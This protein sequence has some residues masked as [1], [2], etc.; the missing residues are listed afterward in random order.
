VRNQDMKTAPV[1]VAKQNTEAADPAPTKEQDH[2]DS[3][4]NSTATEPPMGRVTAHEISHEAAEDMAVRLIMDGDPIALA[5]HRIGLESRAQ[6]K[7]LRLHTNDVELIARQVAVELALGEQAAQAARNAQNGPQ[8]FTGTAL[9]DR[10]AAGRERDPF[11]IYT[12][13]ELDDL[14]HRRRVA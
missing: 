5:C 2:E 9:G 13:D 8:R 3:M 11:P 12:A 1:H 14:E 10:A 7:P 6:P 4:P